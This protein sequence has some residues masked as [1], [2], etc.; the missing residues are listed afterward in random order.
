MAGSRLILSANNGRIAPINFE[1]ITVHKIVKETKN[2]IFISACVKINNL[3]KFTAEST[4]PQITP[5]LNSLNITATPS[6]NPIS[7]V[8]IALITTVDD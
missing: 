1:R 5:T 4:T 8:A 7:P 2:E 3:K 6:L